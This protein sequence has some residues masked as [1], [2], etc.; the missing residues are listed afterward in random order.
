MANT[1]SAFGFRH[2]GYLPGGAPDYQQNTRLIAST[3]TTKIFTGDPIVKVAGTGY[4]AQAANNTTTIDGIFV[5]CKYTPVGGGTPQWS[6]C[7]PGAASADAEAYV[8][9]A[10][11]ALFLVAATNTAIGVAAIGENVGFAI[12]AGSIVGGCFSGA[13]VDQSTL[14]TTNTLP[15]QVVGTYQ[16]VGNGSDATTPYNWVVVTLNNQRFKQLTGVA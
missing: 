13:T 4:I 15:F 5:G 6:P 11:N 14:G 10:P 7:W 16:G 9:E 3:N 2:I 1:Q 8:I 12:G